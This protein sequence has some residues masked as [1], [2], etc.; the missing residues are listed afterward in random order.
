[1]RQAM[2]FSTPLTKTRL[3]HFLFL[4]KKHLYFSMKKKEDRPDGKIIVV[5]ALYFRASCNLFSPFNLFLL[6]SSGSGVMVY[7]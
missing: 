1:M 5:Q 6:A 4:F 3:A 7:A 2:V